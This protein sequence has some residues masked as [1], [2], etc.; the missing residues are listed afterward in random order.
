MSISDWDGVSPANYFYDLRDQLKQHVY[1]RSAR[2]FAAGDAARDAITTPKALRERQRA[3]RETL[4][5][6]I[7]GLPSMETPLEP[8]IV[9]TVQGNG[10]RIEKVIFQSR[11][12]Q[13]VTANLYLPNNRK[14]PGAVVQ[15]L[16]GHHK[17]AK[18]QPEYQIVC[19]YLAQA[20]LIVLAQDPVGQGERFSYYTPGQEKLDVPWGCP[21]HDHA[22]AQCL[23]LGDAMARYFLHDSMRGIDYLMSRPEVDPKRIGVT[24]NSGG[25]T[26]TSLMMM[27]DP[28]IA[29]AAPATFIMSRES[30]MAAG[31]AQDAEQIWPGMTAAGFDHEDI[32]LAMAPRPVR[33]L[34]VTG[35]FFPIE[36]T[37]RTVARCRRF[38][39]MFDR[40]GGLALSEDQSNHAYTRLL[41]RASAQFFADHFL[42]RD[43]E[44]NDSAIAPFEPSELW[45]TRSGQVRGEIPGAGF[46]FEENRKRLEELEA[47]RQAAS[48]DARREKAVKWLRS[49]VFSERIPCD[50]NPRFYHR[51]RHED[52]SAEWAFW[53]SQEGIFN[54]GCLLRELQFEGRALPV[55]LAVWDGG[56]TAITAHEEWVRKRCAGGE[57]ILV[58]DVSG[59]GAL[60]PH[61]ITLAAPDQFYGV[62]HKL[63]DDLIWI[64]DDLAALRTFDTHRALRMIEE[65]PGLDA[66]KIRVYAHGRQGLYARLAAILDARLRDIEVIDGIS[67]FAEWCGDR[68]YDSRDIYSIILRGVLEYFDLPEME[69]APED[70]G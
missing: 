50:L 69:G 22:G 16:C 29:A 15:F 25:G 11:P 67:S 44:L 46:V 42:D 60:A 51:A 66:S 23:P 6:N 63:A 5:R 34:A 61:A 38:W 53:W 24:G 55:T 52:L 39:E 32:L 30:Y 40:P 28:R 27:A 58:L 19:Q 1:G 62:I 20:G 54:H 3:I 68:L 56:T 48:P 43:P 57:A 2:A 35:D 9:G 64:G 4:I 59:V 47:R 14:E 26:Q 21:E 10:F 33:V 36:G 37:L 70:E 41:A 17:D 65:W 49:R 12:G 13:Y 31:G 8:Q 45:C 18:H 7:G